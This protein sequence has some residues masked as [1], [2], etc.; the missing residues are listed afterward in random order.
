MRS[1]CQASREGEVASEKIDGPE[2]R[3]RQR[4]GKARPPIPRS[5]LWDVIFRGGSCQK[6]GSRGCAQGR[7]VQATRMALGPNRVFGRYV[8]VALAWGVIGRSNG[9][10]YPDAIK[11]LFTVPL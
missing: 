7:A 5:F 2:R 1:S 8:D 9:I 10:P 6:S 11:H 4:H 3:C